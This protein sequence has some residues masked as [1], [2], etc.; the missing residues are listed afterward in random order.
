MRHLIPKRLDSN[1]TDRSQTEEELST[2]TMC[3]R[4]GSYEEN[5]SDCRVAP[6]RA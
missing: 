5:S 4:S 2:K 1:L 6:T 3:K